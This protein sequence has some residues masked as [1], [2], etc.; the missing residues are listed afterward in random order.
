[1]ARLGFR[2]W[3]A[4][5][6]NRALAAD[7][8][9]IVLMYYTAAGIWA[10]HHSLLNYHLLRPPSTCMDLIVPTSDPTEVELE[11]PPGWLEADV[12]PS[13]FLSVNMDT[14]MEGFDSPETGRDFS[15]NSVLS[16]SN[17]I[18]V[19]V[20]SAA[21]NFTWNPDVLSSPASPPRFSK[22]GR[23][24]RRLPRTG[25]PRTG[26]NYEATQ[27][28]HERNFRT[29]ATQTEP[30]QILNET[31]DQSASNGLVL[32]YDRSQGVSPPSSQLLSES[33]PGQLYTPVE[34]LPVISGQLSEDNDGPGASGLSSGDIFSLVNL[35]TALHEQNNIISTM[36][37]QQHGRL[38]DILALLHRHFAS[39]N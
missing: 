7:A 31:K 18:S 21:D 27:Q 6:H 32:S 2:F 20:W 17:N 35:V 3:W 39:T 15:S 14:S 19:D 33:F 29:V 11:L 26:L 30:S 16:S 25:L 22:H 13:S 9:V 5:P 38:K 10:Q 4:Q 34:S 24:R 28:R 23:I 37:A 1:M 36:A 8:D 12:P